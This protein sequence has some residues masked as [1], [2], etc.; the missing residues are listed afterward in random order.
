[1]PLFAGSKKMDRELPD[2]VLEL[3]RAYS[4]PLFCGYNEARIFEFELSIHTFQTLK[5]KRNDPRVREQLKICLNLH[6]DKKQKYE[7]YLL[8]GTHEMAHEKANVY[9]QSQWRLS[10]SL[11]KLVSLCNG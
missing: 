2:D 3:I 4:K 9:S 11:E 5:K 8:Y 6:A 7:D 1:M 10:V